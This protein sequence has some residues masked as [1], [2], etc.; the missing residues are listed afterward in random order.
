MVHAQ[1]QK[2]QDSER[3]ETRCRQDKTD[4]DAVRDSS[5]R[6]RSKKAA[7]KGR[8]SA[9]TH[10]KKTESSLQLQSLAQLVAGQLSLLLNRLGNMSKRLLLQVCSF[11]SQTVMNFCLTLFYV[12]ASVVFYRGRYDLRSLTLDLVCTP[13]CNLLARLLNL[14][15]LTVLLILINLG[16]Y[17]RN[18]HAH[19]LSLLRQPDFLR[20]WHTGS[21]CTRRCCSHGNKQY[22]QSLHSSDVCCGV[23]VVC[24]P[25]A[26]IVLEHFDAS[27]SWQPQFRRKT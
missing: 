15:P 14:L 3:S 4:G 27:S 2:C 13:Q 23:F 21:R 16:V 24:L 5:T 10:A 9:R 20:I 6:P 18:V 8:N 12:K 11:L 19:N 1:K 17:K 26:R 7:G 25:C 22:F